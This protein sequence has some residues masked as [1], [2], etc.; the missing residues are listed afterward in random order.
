MPYVRVA[1]V[2]TVHDGYTNYVLPTTSGPQKFSK[3][4]VLKVNYFHLLRK[5]VFSW[6]FYWKRNENTLSTFVLHVYWIIYHK[7]EISNG[8][9]G[10][11]CFILTIRHS[12]SLSKFLSLKLQKRCC[13]NRNSKTES[14]HL[15]STYVILP[16]K[17]K[18]KSV[19]PY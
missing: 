4:R 2:V 8:A 11:K 5:K 1:N 7:F 19:I 16:W 17:A 6:K 10:Q 9:F 3:I 14:L 13:I 18:N 15:S 12:Y